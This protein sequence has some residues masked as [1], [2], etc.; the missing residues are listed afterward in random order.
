MAAPLGAELKI[1]FRSMSRT[2]RRQLILVSLLMPATAIAETAMVAA[3]VPFLTLLAGSHMPAGGIPQLT[4]MLDQLGRFL[5]ANPLIA[6]ALPFAIAVLATAALRLAL[7]W[8]SQ[9]FSFGL[10]QELDVE[11]QK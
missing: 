3:I 7:S 8:I 1:L 10:G 6:A 2:R 9:Q 11:I 5:P 4:G